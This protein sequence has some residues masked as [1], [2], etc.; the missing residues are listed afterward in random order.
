MTDPNSAELLKQLPWGLIFTGIGIG[1]VGLGTAFAGAA[2]WLFK[3][4]VD[5]IKDGNKDR[6]G[7]LKDENAR[8]WRELER[9]RKGEDRWKSEYKGLAKAEQKRH[10]VQQ[11]IETGNPSIIPTSYDESSD[12]T[13]Q[14]YVDTNDRL[15]H[16]EER[17]RR[18]LAERSS[19]MPSSPPLAGFGNL[20]PAAAQAVREFLNNFPTMKPPK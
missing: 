17:Q 7:D 11:V 5:D 3:G 19:G 16:D 2:R 6:I 9:A 13:L 10:I 4:R 8:L 14:I 1:A 18:M 15:K 12:D 20:E